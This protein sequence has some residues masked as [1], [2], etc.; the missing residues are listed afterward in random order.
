MCCLRVDL[1]RS[2]TNQVRACVL[3]IEP[4]T[5]LVGLSLRSHLLQPVSDV[6]AAPPGG[7][8]TGEVV[9]ECKMTAMHHM[10]GAMLELPD[11][12]PAFAHVSEAGDL[13]NLL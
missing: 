12:T 3:Y 9:M 2:V 6:D 5:R 7:D 4:T 10:S 13:M 11:K 8:R 1:R